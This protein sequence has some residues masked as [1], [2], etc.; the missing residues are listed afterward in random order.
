[1]R[2]RQLVLEHWA[3][4]SLVEEA[5]GPVDDVQRFS[6]RIVGPN[7]TRR[8]ED[9]AAGKWR[10]TSLAGHRLRPPAEEVANRHSVK[11]IS[12]ACE[13]RSGADA[14]RDRSLGERKPG[15]IPGVT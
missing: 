12:H 4:E 10:P 14:R 6:L 15:F 5:C 1:M 11:P 9:R 7:S 8:T 2:A 3:H 13:T